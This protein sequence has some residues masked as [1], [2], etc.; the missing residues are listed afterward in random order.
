[1]SGS[2]TIKSGLHLFAL[3]I[4]PQLLKWEWDAF[5]LNLP[6]DD[7]IR[8]LK[9]KHWKDQQ[10]ALLGNV[11]VRW[12][13]RRFTSV[14]HVQIARSENGRPYLAGN[15]SWN[16]DFNI[17]HSGEW[18]VVALTNQGHV[19]VDVERIDH[20]NEDIMAYAMSEAEIKVINHKT[21]MDRVTLFYELW[22]MKEAIYKTGLFPNA[23]PKSLDTVELKGKR[24]D[25]YTKL[26]YVDR[27][28]P[29]SICWNREQPPA[30]LTALDRN[31]L[32]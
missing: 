16:G 21:K 7:R 8:I 14:R 22:T 17:S 19:G 32:I 29:V 5:L 13:I 30:K 28:H 6:N 27:K 10:R 24:K 18:I 23:T 15:N 12:M 2:R 4:G 11:L 26:Y 9:Y 20:L 31:Q 25:I 3:N 1:M